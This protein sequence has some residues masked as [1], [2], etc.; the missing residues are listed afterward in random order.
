MA[1]S[2]VHEATLEGILDR[3]GVSVQMAQWIV[4]TRP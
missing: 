4:E 1:G 3:F 2:G